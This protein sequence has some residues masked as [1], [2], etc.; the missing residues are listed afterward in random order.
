MGRK[1]KNKGQKGT[2]GVLSRKDG[3]EGSWK[4]VTLRGILEEGE[5]MGR[6]GGGGGE[7][8]GGGSSSGERR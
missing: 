4:E 1:R 2:V 8:G 6:R 7:E 3:L 5:D